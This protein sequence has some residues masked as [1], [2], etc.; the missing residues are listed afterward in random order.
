[1]A[2]VKNPINWLCGALALVCGATA[3]ALV[4]APAAIASGSAP[5]SAALSTPPIPTSGAYLGAWVNPLGLLSNGGA[6]EIPQLPKFNSQIGKP[7]AVLH[8]YTLFADPFPTETLTAVEANGS[9]PLVDWSCANVSQI[10][11]GAL[12]T[13]IT[14]EAQSFKAFAK[15]VFF[16]WF[17]EMDANSYA[18]RLCGAYGNGPAFIAAWQR[19]WNIFHRVGA[20]NVAF[21]WCPSSHG[22]ASPYYPGDAYVDWV[23][24]DAYDRANLGS[25]TLHHDF[26]HFYAQWAGR[27][28]PIMVGETA[29]R[30][31]DQVLYIQSIQAQLPVSYPKIKALMYFD[32][33][34]DFDNWSL[35]GNGLTAFKTLANTP[36]F[37]Y[38]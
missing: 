27:N 37:S 25:L 15:P 16:R 21:V 36:Y 3:L 9:I 35:Q 4:G 31:L 7:L 8:V 26:A 13:T 28:K 30:A 2:K 6:N 33:P 29:A 14:T 11:G 12:D 23:A 19:I 10:N 22:D 18:H 5:P 1:M 32:A 34:G 20:T 24:A 17:W 38:R